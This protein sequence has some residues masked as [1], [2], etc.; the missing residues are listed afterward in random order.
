MFEFCLSSIPVMIISYLKKQYRVE[1]PHPT[2]LYMYSIFQ[3]LNY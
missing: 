2:I 1:L 3:E